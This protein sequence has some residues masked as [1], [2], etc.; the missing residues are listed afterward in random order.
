MIRDEDIRTILN[1]AHT[2]AVYGMSQDTQKPAHY[3]PAFLL[4]QGY[5]IIPINPAAEVILNLPCYKRL[6]DIPA[7]IDMLAVFRPAAEVMQ[8]IND[9]INRKN[10]RGDI[11]VIWLQDGIYNEPA[12]QVAEN[13][14]MVV[15]QDRC[16][17][18][19]YKRLSPKDDR[20]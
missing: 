20:R 6:I 15:I 13:A 9:A 16:L 19:E 3:V 2:I 14:G 8:I 5:V 12:R 11:G 17:M 1:T 18:K 7:P 4:R 10:M